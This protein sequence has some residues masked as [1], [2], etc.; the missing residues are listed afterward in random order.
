MRPDPATIFLFKALEA[1]VDI[2]VTAV[3][4]AKL[5]RTVNRCDAS[6]NAT[7]NNFQVIRMAFRQA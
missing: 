6:K 1:F 5:P 3:I 7:A 2:R 4:P